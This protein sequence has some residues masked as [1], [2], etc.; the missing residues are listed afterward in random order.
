MRKGTGRG[1]SVKTRIG[2]IVI[3][4]RARV[5]TGAYKNIGL[6]NFIAIR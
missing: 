6:S 5:L 4:P 1:R 2:D 3:V